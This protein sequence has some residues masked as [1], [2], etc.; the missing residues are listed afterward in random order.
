MYN[1]PFVIAEAGCNHMGQMEIAKEL[2]ITA[3]TFCKADSI[4]F[5]KRCPKELL[6]PEQ[7]NAPHP[8][9]ANSYGETYGAHREF[10][11]MNNEC[12]I[13]LNQV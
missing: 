4:K 12:V 10:L 6:T 11:E 5:Q 9:P 3:A 13:Q 7:Y 8:N 2:I 1:K